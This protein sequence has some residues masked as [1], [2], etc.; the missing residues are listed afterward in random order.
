M[1]GIRCQFRDPI[2]R[3]LCERRDTKIIDTTIREKDAPAG[4]GLIRT[5]LIAIRCPVHR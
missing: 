5:F 3:Q 4:A 1:R 2:T